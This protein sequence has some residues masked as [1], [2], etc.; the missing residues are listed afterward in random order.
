MPEPEKPLTYADAVRIKA[1]ER[2]LAPQ[3]A[4]I[5]VE[6][7][8]GGTKAAQIARDLHLTEGRVHQILRA[9]RDQ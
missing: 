8:D 7:R 1:E 2:Q 6:A 9:H 4:R 3:L 5:I